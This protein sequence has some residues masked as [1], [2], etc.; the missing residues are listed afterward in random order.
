M[1]SVDCDKPVKMACERTSGAADERRGAFIRSF[2]D[3]LLAR[4]S[5]RQG[6]SLCPARGA[7]TRGK[8]AQLT[9]TGHSPT[10]EI[11]DPSIL[12]P[13]GNRLESTVRY[14]GVDIENAVLLAEGTEV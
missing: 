10:R 7:P 3:V 1:I 8:S 4:G 14:L 5:A 13:A 6:V 9:T 11:V 12:L 2:H